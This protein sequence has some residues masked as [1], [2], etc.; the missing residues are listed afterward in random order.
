MQTSK[1]IGVLVLGMSLGASTAFAADQAPK[2]GASKL[3]CPAGS[4]QFGN[5]N[6]GLFCRKTVSTDGYNVPHGPY[7]AYHAGGQK[8]VD[9]QY[10]EGFRSGTWVYYDTSG[11]VTEKIEFSREN[12]NGKREQFFSNG[13]L[14]LV[15]EYVAGKRQGLTQ[16]FS[17]D[18]KVVREARYHDDREVAAK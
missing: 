3:K 2:V 11:K 7:T 4:S 14:R 15:E 8:S 10:V 16:E 18:G 9:G 6:D 17:E 5:P 12:Y 1:L 13:K